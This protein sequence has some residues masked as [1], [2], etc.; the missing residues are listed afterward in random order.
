MSPKGML[1]I[2]KAVRLGWQRNHN[3]GISAD[4]LKKIKKE[5]AK[6]STESANKIRSLKTKIEKIITKLK[7]EGGHGAEIALL[8]KYKLLV[9]KLEREHEAKVKRLKA[10]SEQREKDFQATMDRI[11]AAQAQMLAFIQRIDEAISQHA[12]DAA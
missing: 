11:E 10:Y 4:E 7:S 5:L 1:I 8:E 9:V 3:D 6:A 12:I 2:G